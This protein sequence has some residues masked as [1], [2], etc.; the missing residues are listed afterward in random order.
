MSANPPRQ[1]PHNQGNVMYRD[2]FAHREYRSSIDLVNEVLRA[3]SMAVHVLQFPMPPRFMVPYLRDQYLQRDLAGATRFKRVTL[4]S[5]L[6]TE[7]IHPDTLI[8]KHFHARLHFSCTIPQNVTYLYGVSRLLPPDSTASPCW[9]VS[10]YESYREGVWAKG[11]Y[12]LL[13]I[14]SDHVFAQDVDLLYLFKA[15]P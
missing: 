12:Y 11:T 4:I 3:N 10:V 8:H 13:R 2:T 5:E 9:D 1:P 7:R 14:E 6:D 15:L